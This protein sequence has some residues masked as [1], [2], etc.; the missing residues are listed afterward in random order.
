MGA[1]SQRAGVWCKSGG[2]KAQ[3]S[4]RSG[5][6]EH[7]SRVGRLAPLKGFEQFRIGRKRSGLNERSFPEKKGG[8]AGKLSPSLQGAGFFICQIGRPINW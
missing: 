4:P 2:S 6:P 3:N 7:C 5:P 8:T 1:L